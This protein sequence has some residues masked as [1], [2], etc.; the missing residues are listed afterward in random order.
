VDTRVAE[1]K[2]MGFH[3]CLLPESNL[4]RLKKIQDITLIGIKSISD[5]VESLF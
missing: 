3:R 4:K 2:K 1:M 5:A